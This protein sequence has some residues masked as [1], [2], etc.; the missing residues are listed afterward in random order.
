MVKFNTRIEVTDS[1][2]DIERAFMDAIGDRLNKVL[3][4]ASRKIRT[5][6][7]VAVKEAIED[8]REFRSL[9]DGQLRAEFG[10]PDARRRIQ[11]ILSLWIASIEVNVQKFVVTRGGFNGGL[12]VQMIR[13]NFDDVLRLPE[14]SFITRKGSS[15]DWL[16]WLL[17][18]GDKV[19]IRDY[20]IEFGSFRGVGQRSRTGDARM[21][22]VSQ[23]SWRVPPEFS[24]TKTNNF[25]TRSLSNIEDTLNDIVSNEILQRII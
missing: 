25:V 11:A 23:G 8:S 13:E 3:S 9:T 20:V 1:T 7:R 10:L 4:K 17:L 2:D 22:F 18:E 24:G 15:L 21:K 6:V 16:R 14:S 12:T 19:I 5:R